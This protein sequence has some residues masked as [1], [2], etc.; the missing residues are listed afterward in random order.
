MTSATIA[1]GV[2]IKM[3]ILETPAA[4]PHVEQDYPAFWLSSGRRGSR[5]AIEYGGGGGCIQDRQ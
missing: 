4:T 2:N 1:M 5:L 3:S